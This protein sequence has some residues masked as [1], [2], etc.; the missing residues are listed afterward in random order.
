MNSPPIRREGRSAP[1]DRAVLRR[2]RIE[3]GLSQV[4][5]ATVTGLS[6]SLISALECGESG[7]SPESLA[8]IAKALGCTVADLMQAA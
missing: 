7:A 6:T 1:Y 3:A 8:A 5:L 4:R 2:K